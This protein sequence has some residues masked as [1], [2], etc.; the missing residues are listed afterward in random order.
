MQVQNAEYN[1]TQEVRFAVVMYGGVSLAV[2]MN[3]I[4][5][6]LLSVVRATANLPDAALSSTEPVYRQLGRILHHDRTPGD[7]ENTREIRTRIVVDILSGTSAGGINAIFL[8]KALSQKNRNLQL[9]KDMWLREADIDRLLNDRIAHSSQ[10]GKTSLL[11]SQRMYDLL[12][13]ALA[14]METAPKDQSGGPLADQI[15]LFV[16]ATDLNGLPAPIELTDKAIEERIHRMVFHFCEDDGHFQEKFNPMLAFAARCTS[17]FPVAFE[18]MKFASAFPELQESQKEI[19]GRFFERYE[20][21]GA[22]Y[23]HR[24]FADGGYLDNRPF[25]YAVEALAYRDASRPVTRKLLF[26]DPSPEYSSGV[27]RTNVDFIENTLAAASELPRYETIREDIERIN[28]HNRLQTR[29]EALRKRVEEDRALRPEPPFAAPLSGEEYIEQDLAGMIASYGQ[30]YAPY[31]HRKVFA[32]TDWIARVATRVLGHNE[33]SDEFRAIRYLIRAWR[34]A[35]YAPYRTSEKATENKFLLAYDLDY[36]LRRLDRLRT[37]IDEDLWKPNA[38]AP[39]LRACRARVQEQLSSLLKFQRSLESRTQSPLRAD[40]AKAGNT[41]AASDLTA[42]L[43]PPTEERRRE[44]AQGKYDSHAVLIQELA[45]DLASVLKAKFTTAAKAMADVLDPGKLAPDASQEE[46]ETRKR[47]WEEYQQFDLRDQLNLQFLEGVGVRES[48]QVEIYRI[49]PADTKLKPHWAV[50]G[51]Q[52]LAGV[53]LGHFGAFLSERWRAN[54]IMWGRLDGAERII[55]ALLPDEKDASLRECLIHQAQEQILKE[56]FDPKTDRALAWLVDY[57]RERVPMQEDRE[58]VVQQMKKL[59]DA[60]SAGAPGKSVAE[61]IAE[62]DHLKFIRDYYQT[63]PPP[64]AHL[65]LAWVARAVRIL[66]EMFQGLPSEGLAR[67]LGGRVKLTGVLLSRIVAFALPDSVWRLLLRH[68]LLLIA[69]AGGVLIAYGSLVSK[70]QGVWLAGVAALLCAAAVWIAIAAVG[71]WLGG[72]SWK[73][74]KGGVK[75]TVVAAGIGLSA[76]GGW[77]VWKWLAP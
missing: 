50:R 72:S 62:G 15:D 53:S 35:H 58:E 54:D 17:S 24:P 75:L 64:P 42:I 69:L 34:E 5:Q 44:V 59:A 3:G 52:K 6:E 25:S 46:R 31:H 18:P 74:F 71:S 56:E 77:T 47:L 38:A 68:W 45:D 30:G 51:E 16:T 2:Y 57:V 7:T 20:A 63:P 70:E 60:L 73:T 48:G 55:T 27:D 1:P 37:A 32:V 28:Q 19:F 26:L 14:R 12:L 43:N 11:N 21:L 49:S 9:L 4:A 65:E 33:D 29:L 22:D 41:V 13:E 76:I 39:A 8:A 66:G 61:L 40:L 36:R 67:K 23:K 10:T